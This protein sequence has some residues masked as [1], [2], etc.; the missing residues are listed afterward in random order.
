MR[1]CQS[2]GTPPRTVSIQWP[3]LD[4]SE[5]EDSPFK[6]FSDPTL[7]PLWRN[8]RSQSRDLRWKCQVKCEA[9]KCDHELV[10]SVIATDLIYFKTST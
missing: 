1:T 10:C 8:E 4:P 3:K 9:G 7:L 6:E 5:P 2:R